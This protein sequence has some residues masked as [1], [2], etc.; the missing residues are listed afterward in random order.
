MRHSKGLEFG[1]PVQYGTAFE[2]AVRCDTERGEG[3]PR[4]LES[5]KRLSGIACIP[6]AEGP[7]GAIRIGIPRGE[8]AARRMMHLAEQEP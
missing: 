3:E 7:F 6:N 1:A 5:G 8:E 2:V 4:V